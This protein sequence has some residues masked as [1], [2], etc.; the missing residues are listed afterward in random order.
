MQRIRIPYTASLLAGLMILGV[1]L[2][3]R[4]RW[5]GCGAVVYPGDRGTYYNSKDFGK[6]C[7]AAHRVRYHVLDALALE[8]SVDYRRQTV[9]ENTPDE[10]KIHTYPVQASL[11]FYLF[12]NSRVS[13]FVL[14]GAGWYY[15]TVS[16]PG[17]YSNTQNRFGPHVGGGVEF[18][19]SKQ[20]SVDATYRYVWIEDVKSQNAAV[21]NKDYKDDG[22]MI[23]AGLNLHF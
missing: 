8:G 9:N 17:D 18:Y 15:T 20:L 7:T 5:R 13:P 3:P 12:P 22:S 4:Y 21:E 19:L 6:D 16:G 1:P 14:G 2:T 11:L 23:T 10:T